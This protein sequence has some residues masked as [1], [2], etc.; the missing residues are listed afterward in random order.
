MKINMEHW[1]NYTDREKAKY[2]EEN[3][4]LGIWFTKNSTE[5][6]LGSKS[7]LCEGLQLN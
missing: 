3:L 7:C 5:S 1:W 6:G 2:C 4:G